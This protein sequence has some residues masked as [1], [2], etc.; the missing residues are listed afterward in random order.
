MFANSFAFPGLHCCVSSIFSI[1]FPSQHRDNQAVMPPD[2]KNN[3]GYD[4]SGSPHENT[5]TISRVDSQVPDK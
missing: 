4:I 5:K 2:R 3:A 1:F